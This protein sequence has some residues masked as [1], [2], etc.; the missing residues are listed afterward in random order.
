MWHQVIDQMRRGL[1]LRVVLSTIAAM[2]SLPIPADAGYAIAALNSGMIV[3]TDTESGLMRVCTI[4]RGPTDFFLHCGP[5]AAPP[6]AEN[7]PS[8]KAPWEK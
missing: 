8:Q 4:E 2:A 1:K 5:W 6:D 3:Q 7:E